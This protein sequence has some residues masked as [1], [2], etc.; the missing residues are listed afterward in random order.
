M[1]LVG[2]GPDIE[3]FKNISGG[4]QKVI[5]WGRKV[6]DVDV[7]FAACD[8]F[9]LP[10]LGG[11]ALNQAMFWCKPC[12][13][14]EADGTEDDLIKDNITGYKFRKN[15]INSL[16]QAMEK[17]ICITTNDY[18]LMSAK[19]SNVIKSYTNVESMVKTF[20]KTLQSFI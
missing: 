1:W 8:Y 20:E 7:Y 10:G 17:L 11:L 9:V 18:N 6:E 4:D 2:D 19:C 13:V 16:E 3:F 5:Y 15:D 12:I 14:S